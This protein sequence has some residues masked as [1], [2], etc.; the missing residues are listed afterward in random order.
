M[1]LSFA[2]EVYEI[3]MFDQPEI[4]PHV[5]AFRYTECD[6][7]TEVNVCIG[8]TESSKIGFMAVYECR[9]CFTKYRCHI[10]S[11]GRYNRQEFLDDLGLEIWARND[12]F[13]QETC[14]INRMPNNKMKLTLKGRG[15]TSRQLS[16]V[17]TAP[18]QGSLF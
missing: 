3:Q 15:E 1:K 9:Q 16:S 12:L 7:L 8:Y 6:R 11:T 4:F 14:N 17:V 10:N 13:K 5:R 18:L 2:D